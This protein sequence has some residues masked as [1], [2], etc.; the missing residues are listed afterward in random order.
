MGVMA[1][2]DRYSDSRTTYSGGV[3]YVPNYPKRPG[4]VNPNIPVGQRA[5]SVYNRPYVDSVNTFYFDVANAA[6]TNARLIREAQERARIQAEALRKQREAEALE[7]ARRDA[8]ATQMDMFDPSQPGGGVRVTDLGVRPM[9]GVQGITFAPDFQTTDKQLAEAIAKQRGMYAFPVMTMRNGN[10]IYQLSNIPPSQAALGGQTPKNPTDFSLVPAAATADALERRTMRQQEDLVKLREGDLTWDQLISAWDGVDQS[11]LDYLYNL[12]YYQKAVDAWGQPSEITDRVI[13]GYEDTDPNNPNSEL[14]PIWSEPRV[15]GLDWQY[16]QDPDTGNTI[17]GRPVAYLGMSTDPAKLNLVAMNIPTRPKPGSDISEWKA[18]FNA[19]DSGFVAPKYMPESV[20]ET[21]Q[22]MPV[23]QRIAMQKKFIAA[24]LYETNDPIKF[25]R[26]S[27]ED[28]GIMTSLMSDANNQGITWEQVLDENI[29]LA[30]KMD[31]QTAAS[32]GYGGGGGGGGTTVYKQVQ[33]NQTSVAQARS[34]LIGVLTEALGRYPT[35][36]E[37]NQ[38]LD[39]LNKQE[40]KSPSRT[41]TE[42]TTTGDTTRAVTRMS[43]STVDAQA[44]AEEFARGLGGYDES[45]VNRYLN[46]LF[47]SLG[48]QVV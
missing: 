39:M 6:A 24:H 2:E 41:I 29:M 7:R 37:V 30:R 11:E 15:V 21:L 17:S 25:G 8:Q 3:K 48:E 10:T 46:G 23:E 4:D 13:I 19:L 38:F 31:R 26:I 43:P 5:L 14:K 18:Y 20:M 42:T 33:Y 9:G 1:V 32:S 16:K 47:D 22:F 35:D 40:K 45:A 12:K 27:P 34:L 36:K 28:A 44:L